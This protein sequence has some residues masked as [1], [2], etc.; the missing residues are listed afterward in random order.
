MGV[1]LTSC[2]MPCFSAIFVPLES[3]Q[4][5]ERERLKK[6]KKKCKKEHE[7]EELGKPFLLL[8][9]ISR[10]PRYSSRYCHSNPVLELFPLEHQNTSP[11]DRALD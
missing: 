6:E 8:L 3:M 4:G 1:F 9:C 2:E 7:G 5:G 10:T 11:I